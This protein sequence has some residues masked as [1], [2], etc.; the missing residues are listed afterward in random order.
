MHPA[1]DGKYRPTSASLACVHPECPSYGQTG[2]G[3]LIEGRIR[4]ARRACFRL[5]SPGVRHRLWF[6]PPGPSNALL[7]DPDR[8][9]A[10]LAIEAQDCPWK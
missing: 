8:E 6:V 5:G 3:S 7:G 9:D 4:W 10:S 1:P 2:Q